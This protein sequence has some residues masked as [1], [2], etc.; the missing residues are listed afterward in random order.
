MPSIPIAIAVVEHAGRVLI[1]QRP[2]GGA[3]GGYWEFPGGK[4]AE[5]ETPADAAAREC[6]E[7]TGLAVRVGLLLDEVEHAYE[8]GLLHLSFFHA[9]PI[10]PAEPPREPYRWVA[11]ATLGGYVFPPANAPILARLLQKTPK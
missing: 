7:E 6:W 9:E 3:L 11:R 2:A 8:H 5:G 4:V 1:G 10:D